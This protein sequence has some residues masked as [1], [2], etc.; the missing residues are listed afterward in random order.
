MTVSEQII[1]RI[2]RSRPG[3]VFTRYDLVDLGSPHAVGMVLIRLVRSGRIRRIARGLYDVPRTHRTLGVLAPSPETVA[4]AIARRDGAWI[5]PAEAMAANLL[6][7]SEQV[8]AKI[9]Y[10]TDG[11]RRT[12]RVGRLEIQFVKRPPRRLRSAARMSNLLFSA[13]RSLGQ[14]HVTNERVVHLRKTLAVSD[15]RQLLKDLPSAPAWMHPFVRF[16]AEG[17]VPAARTRRRKTS[18]ARKGTGR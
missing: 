1:G 9:I 7:L 12:I 11:P 8:P 17:Q 14:A 5:Q 2:E 3:W 10:E 15:R 13:L 16:I 4:E 6:N 18:R